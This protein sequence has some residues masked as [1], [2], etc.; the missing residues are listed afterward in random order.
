M[1]QR[2]FNRFPSSNSAVASNRSFCILLD[3]DVSDRKELS[4]FC[5]CGNCSIQKSVRESICCKEAFQSTSP[6]A[7]NLRSVLGEYNCI[8]ET[9]NVLAIVTN[10]FS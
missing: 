1:D 10:S 2:A 4:D 6:F 3:K 5:E 7:A 9:P 8:C